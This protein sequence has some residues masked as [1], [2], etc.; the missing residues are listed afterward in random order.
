MFHRKSNDTLTICKL[1]NKKT[2]HF[3]KP[4]VLRLFLFAEFSKF[5]NYTLFLNGKRCVPVLSD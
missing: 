2:A 1:D 4:L 5:R 3:N